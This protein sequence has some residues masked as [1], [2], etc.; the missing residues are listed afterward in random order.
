MRLN[1][2]VYTNMITMSAVVPTATATRNASAVVTNEP[3]YGMKPP[4]KV[5][6]P[7]GIASGRPRMIMISALVTAPNSEI[8]AVPIM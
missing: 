5:S 8:T 2:I 6:T 4:K 3:M 1:A 7:I